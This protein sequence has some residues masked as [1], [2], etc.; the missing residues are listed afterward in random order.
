[1][2]TRGDV[3][4][5]KLDVLI[6]EDSV[7]YS[8]ELE[9]LCTEIGLNV[10]GNVADSAN[11]LD[12]I[13]SESPDLILMD[14]QIEGRLSGLE[15]G[16][17]TKSWNIPIIYISSFH[18]SAS[19]KKAQESNIYGFLVKPI[20]SEKIQVELLK[21]MK[22]LF[23]VEKE[24]EP[25]MILKLNDQKTFYF[26]K[27][28]IY[29]KIDIAD[30]AY[31]KSDDN[32]C[33]F[34]LNNNEHYLLRITLNEVEIT[35]KEYGFIKSHRSYLVNISK[36][37]ALDLSKNLLFMGPDIEIPFSRSKKEELKN[38]GRFLS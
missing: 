11:A 38:I 15:I 34:V 17:K 28:G 35:L 10:I 31:V 25:K 36:I 3:M 30:L 19:I 21:I 24:D 22:S 29:H 26:L 13:A 37:T 5:S 32:Y 4:K 8:I 7:S 23:K 9:R 1:M 14:I 16:A 20:S 6:V 12:I 18:N 2:F 27:K 33:R